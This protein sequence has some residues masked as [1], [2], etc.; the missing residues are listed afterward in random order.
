M[1][2]TVCRLAWLACCAILL[3][4]AGATPSGRP[5][6]Q[7]GA[8][9]STGAPKRIVAAIQGTP[10]GAYPKLDPNNS[11]RGNGELGGLLH[12]GLTVTDEAIA[13]AVSQGAAD[14]S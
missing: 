4:C 6:S 11:Q 3:A 8:G 7:A 1:G 13:A 9:P 5:S 14:P 10:V 12:A 2:R